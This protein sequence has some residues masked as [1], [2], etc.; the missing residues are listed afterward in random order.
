M[1][2]TQESQK[3]VKWV[4]LKLQKVVTVDVTFLQDISE[5]QKCTILRM[6]E[7]KGM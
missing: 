7:K 6:R 4:N 1:T 5:K 3:A 2:Q